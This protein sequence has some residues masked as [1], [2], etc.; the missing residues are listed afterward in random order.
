MRDLKDVRRDINAIDHEILKLFLKRMKCA[1][2]VSDYKMEHGGQ[3]LVPSRET[4]LMNT[5]LQDI[6]NELKLEYSSLLRTTTRVSRKHQYARMLEAEPQRLQL[7]LHPRNNDPKTVYYGGLPASYA[8]I[9]AKDLF[10]HAQRIPQNSW[11]DVFHAVLDGK[12][13]IGVV[14]VEN[15]T[16]GTVN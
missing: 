3:V 7:D 8:D 6:P 12:A 10:P 13:D 9:A 2:E 1:E 15:S 4:E 5:M 11:E 16:A 14:P